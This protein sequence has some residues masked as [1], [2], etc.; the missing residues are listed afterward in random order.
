MFEFGTDL[1]RYG[2]LTY[3]NYPVPPHRSPKT[4]K[5]KTTEIR[6]RAVVEAKLGEIR[7]RRCDIDKSSWWSPMISVPPW[8]LSASL[9]DRGP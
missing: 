8:T 4:P 7:L 9:V 2:F 6:F 5:V 3:F 1:S